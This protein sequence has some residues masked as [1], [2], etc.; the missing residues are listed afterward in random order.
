M[1]C[2]SSFTFTDA[3]IYALFITF[4]RVIRNNRRISQ[5][6]L[7]TINYNFNREDKLTG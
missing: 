1:F 3:E 6:H 5:N 4:T 2:Y 7:Y